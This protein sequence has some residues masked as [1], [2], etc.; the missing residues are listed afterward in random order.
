[1]KKFMLLAVRKAQDGIK[2]GQAPFGACIAKGSKV[3]A[4]AHNGVW[5]NTDITA[6]AEIRAVR[7]ACKRLKT[8]E[9]SGCVLYSTCEP[10]P[11]CFAACHWA[12]ISKIVYGCRIADA[13]K[14]GFSELVI[15]VAKMKSLGK[16]KVRITGDFMRKESLELF[17]TW[18]K[19]KDSRVY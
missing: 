17:K 8:I 7:A 3:V 12:G 6:H 16:S 15:P 4:C 2:K 14:I 9:L 5:K 19:R 18:A 1:M 13:K 11:M 10:C